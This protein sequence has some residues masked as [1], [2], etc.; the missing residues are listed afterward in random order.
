M[1]PSSLLPLLSLT[2]MLKVSPVRGLHRSLCCG[3]LTVCT[4]QKAWLTP[5]LIGCQALPY[6]VAASCCFRA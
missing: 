5:N 1:H 4:V 2:Y 3:R 6:V